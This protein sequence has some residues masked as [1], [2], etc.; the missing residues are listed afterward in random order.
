MYTSK[1]YE[2]FAAGILLTLFLGWWETGSPWQF[3]LS[4]VNPES[5]PPKVDT[6]LYRLIL[7]LLCL[8]TAL[9]WLAKTAIQRITKR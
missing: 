4:A 7:P 2:W 6:T 9:V 3:F 5:Y 1:T 8:A